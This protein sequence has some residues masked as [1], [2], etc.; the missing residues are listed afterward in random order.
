MTLAEE[1]VAV[2]DLIEDLAATLNRR[3]T[4]TDPILAANEYLFLVLTA[5]RALEPVVV[6]LQRLLARVLDDEEEVA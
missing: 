5:S 1:L 4:P 3:R 6:S 2:M